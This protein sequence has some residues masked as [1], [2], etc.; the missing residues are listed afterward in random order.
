M[1]SPGGD[2]NQLWRSDGAL[3]G[4][5]LVADLTPS[6]PTAGAGG[7]RG[8]TPFAARLYFL[9]PFL[10]DGLAGL[11]RSDGTRAG[12]LPLTALDARSRQPVCPPN[13]LPSSSPPPQQAPRHPSHA[14]GAISE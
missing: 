13:S 2:C 3:G 10:G 12:T 8:L 5:T 1:G 7:V 4:T 11:W 9:S 6:V 14:P